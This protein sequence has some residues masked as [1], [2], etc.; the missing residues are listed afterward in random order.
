MKNG[1]NSMYFVKSHEMIC[2][3]IR[4]YLVPLLPYLERFVKFKMFCL[5]HK[6]RFCNLSRF[7][8]MLNFHNQS[9]LK[10]TSNLNMV[11]KNQILKGLYQ[12]EVTCQDFIWCRF[13]EKFICQVWLSQ[14]LRLFRIKNRML[15]ILRAKKKRFFSLESRFKN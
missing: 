5:M 1:R 11:L 3:F 9:I 13:Q 10:N 12:R 7:N 2:H 4:L 15:L 6:Y 8:L 14:N